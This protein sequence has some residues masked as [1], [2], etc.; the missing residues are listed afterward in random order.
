MGFGTPQDIPVPADYD[1]DGKTDIAVFN[2]PNGTWYIQGSRAGYFSYQWGLP[3]DI[4]VP[5]DYD[6][7]GLAEAAVYRPSN[8]TWYIAPTS[9]AHYSLAFGSYGDAPLGSGYFG[10]LRTTV[11]TLQ[12]TNL[13]H[14][15]LGLNYLVGDTYRLTIT[16]APNQP[17]TMVQTANGALSNQSFGNTDAY[18]DLTVDYLEQTANI[19]SYTQVWSVGGV[20]ASPALSFTIGQLG[21]G[22]TVS[23]TDLGETSDGSVSGASTI[24]I[25]NGS[26]ST[27]SVTELDYTAQFYYDAYTVA[28]LRDYGNV[29]ASGQS[30]ITPGTAGGTLSATANAWDDYTLQT[31][32]YAVAFVLAGGYYQNPLYFGEGS[33][34]DSRGDVIFEPG[35]GVF[36]ITAASI[37]I[38]S[39]VADQTAVPQDGSLS[40]ADDSYLNSFLSTSG[41]IPPNQVTMKVDRWNAALTAA[42]NAS[43]IEHSANPSAV[44]PF[45]LQVVGDCEYGNQPSGTAD[46]QRT[47][48]V[49]DG[50]GHPWNNTNPLLVNENILTYSAG[51]PVSGNGH[52]GTRGLVNKDE[53]LVSGT[54]LDDLTQLT[55]GTPQQEA[56]Q[57]FWATDFNMPN[58]FTLPSIAGF[59]APTIPLL[60]L[61]GMSKTDKGLFGS[62]GDV[63]S[64][65]YIGINGDN[66]N[67]P[68]Q[69]YVAR[70]GG[71]NLP[72]LACGGP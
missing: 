55:I 28:T 33:G 50:Q 71:L 13:T 12:L 17:V 46:R 32:H 38:G 70:S 30:Y 63:Y 3:G 36:Y 29:V 37:Y 2:P 9:A 1:G 14:P 61:D 16:G 65:T 54:F 25:T 51:P 10:Y 24:S 7:D 57:Q 40:I 67:A 68:N 66:G 5:G 6:G 8:V 69:Y 34:D 43:L 31:D 26:V 53:E 35:G 47:Y 15:N 11:P 18:G 45:I 42:W 48:R 58:G 19:G 23:T 62:L 41:S 22:G 60:I 39:T 49:L 72:P 59:P 64:R 56:L 21:T 4:P 27:Y 52:W 44:F 20:Q